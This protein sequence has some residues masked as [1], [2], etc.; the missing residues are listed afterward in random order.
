MFACEK[1]C[2]GYEAFLEIIDSQL[3]EEN[4]RKIIKFVDFIDESLR[5]K[6]QLGIK[7]YNKLPWLE[8]WI[9][10]T[11]KIALDLKKYHIQDAP[12]KKMIKL[13]DNQEDANSN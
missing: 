2:K 6:T 8:E 9:E 10:N 12:L 4:N 3:E 13:P 7:K 5:K 11:K 1:F